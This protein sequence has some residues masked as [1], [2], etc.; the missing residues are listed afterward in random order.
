L[1]YSVAKPKI[2]GVQ[3]D[4]LEDVYKMTHKK[5]EKTRRSSFNRIKAIDTL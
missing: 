5:K 3:F 2:F 1:K 4:E